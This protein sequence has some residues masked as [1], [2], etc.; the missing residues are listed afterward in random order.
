MQATQDRTNEVLRAMLTENTGRHILDSGDAYGRHW[1]H[2]QARDFDSEL[3][4]VLRGSVWEYQGERRAEIELTH[5]VYHWLSERVTYDEDL[6]RLFGIFSASRED[7]YWM[8]DMEDFPAWLSEQRE[9]AAEELE[10]AGLEPENAAQCFP[11]AP[12]GIYG[13]AS[14]PLTVNTYNSEDALSQVLQFVYWTDDMGEHCL[15]QIHG[16][17]DVRGGYTRPRA[18]ECSIEEYSILDNARAV[19]FCQN[20]AEPEHNPGQ[21]TVTGDEPNE[22]CCAMWTTDDA[23]YSWSGEWNGAGWNT[24]EVRGLGGYSNRDGYPIEPGEH[25]EKGKIVVHEDGR[26]FCPV[27]GR[28]TLGAGSY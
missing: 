23:G 7:T 6:D 17:A 1:Q 2:N 16:G 19:M 12:G 8:E 10:A 4:T 22:R 3:P 14:G 26:I 15:L 27:C 11:D 9:R 18:F 28:S 24:H 13:D 5:N 25:G 21:L 20:D